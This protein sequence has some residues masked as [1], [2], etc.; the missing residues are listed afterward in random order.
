MCLLSAGGRAKL[1]GSYSGEKLWVANVSAILSGQAVIFPYTLMLMRYFQSF[2]KFI[3]LNCF[4]WSHND[5]IAKKSCY[6]E[7][8]DKNNLKLV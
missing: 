1:D 7:R 2:K 3:L 4:T 5:C 6:E 8:Q